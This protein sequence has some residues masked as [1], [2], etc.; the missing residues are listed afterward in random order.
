MTTQE[1]DNIAR[2]TLAIVC[3]IVTLFLA[4]SSSW[5]LIGTGIFTC[6][7]LYEG[8]KIHEGAP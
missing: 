8:F 3:I 7:L 6:W 4:E 5:Y 2:L 1:P